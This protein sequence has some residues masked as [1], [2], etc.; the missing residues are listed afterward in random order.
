MKKILV[1]DQG[2]T[3]SRAILF[4]VNGKLLKS[5]Q[6]AIQQS[7]P[8]PGWV[9]HDPEAIFASVITCCKEVLKQENL[10]NILGVGIANQRETTVVFERQTGRA[11]YPAIVWQDR[12][13]A[14]ACLELEAF[15][16]AVYQ[17]TGLKLD[18]YFSATKLAWIL[19]AKNAYQVAQQGELLFGTIDSYLIWRLTQ[20]AVHATDIT[21]ASRTLLFNIHTTTWDEELLQLFNI[22][23]A[24]LPTVLENCADFGFVDAA[25]FGE[26]LP[27]LAVMGD[28]QAAMVGQGCL[29][30]GAAKST[31]GTGCFLMVNT[32]VMPHTNSHN[33]LTTIAYQI[34]GK[35]NYAVEGSIF[36]CGSIIKWFIDGLEIVQNPDETELLASQIDNNGGVY[37]VPAFTGLGAPYWQPDARGILTGLKRDTSKAHLVRAGLESIAY[38]TRDLLGG[39]LG[40][41]A[42]NVDGGVTANT[43]LMQFL[44]NILQMPIKI[45]PNPEATALGIAYL[46]AFQAGVMG[47]LASIKSFNTAPAIIKPVMP[48]EEADVLHQ[49][50]QIAVKK[51]LLE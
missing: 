7:F 26:P 41:S 33:L 43:W 32:G 24:M 34:Q 3:S 45:S 28:Q 8:N 30:P 31:Y 9:E 44:A 4:S 29:E 12:R 6:V 10:K 15:S 2:T 47:S 35:L 25:L 17:K 49:E 11:I 40:L 38:Q 20:G 46:V 22:P 39:D 14:Q 13:T 1:I 37:L 36:A 42:L 50:W 23:S 21:N 51:C 5:H 48:K 27:I 19:A 16:D 18:P